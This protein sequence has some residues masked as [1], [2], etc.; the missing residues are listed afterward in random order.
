MHIGMG[1]TKMGIRQ[2]WYCFEHQLQSPR[3]MGVDVTL[4][5]SFFENIRHKFWKM[6]TK[7]QN[8][9]LWSFKRAILLNLYVNRP[10]STDF[11]Y[12][13]HK[14]RWVP[15]V[16]PFC[17]QMYNIKPVTPARSCDLLRQTGKMPPR[18]DFFR[19]P[20]LKYPENA[21]VDSWW[22]VYSNSTYLRV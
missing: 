5:I 3:D 21:T 15:G 10:P 2:V 4:T 18:N 7:K 22:F 8:T 9:T 14:T 17:L 6:C 16:N 1:V 11:F 20:P 19:P 13:E 12:T